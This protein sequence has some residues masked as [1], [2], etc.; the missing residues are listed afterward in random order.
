MLRGL[1]AD[2]KKLSA[3]ADDFAIFTHS[4]YACAYFHYLILLIIRPLVKS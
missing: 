2:N 3:S 4:F 1:W